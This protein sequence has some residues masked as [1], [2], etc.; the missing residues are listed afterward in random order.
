[1]NRPAERRRIVALTGVLLFVCAAPLAAQELRYFTPD[2]LRQITAAR[3]GRPFVL[4]LWSI[5]CIH[6]QDELALL[7]RLRRTHPRLDLVLIA[8]DTPD[9]AEPIAATLR[10]HGLDGVEVWVFADD[11]SERLRFSIDRRWR[12]ELPRTYLYA[13]DHSTRVLS[14]RPDSVQLEEWIER[15]AQ[16]MSRP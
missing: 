8:T 13:P 5:T 10:R 4:G 9:D 14:G 6:C 16:A 1:M 2:S 11:F 12:G 7:G 3:P 15:H